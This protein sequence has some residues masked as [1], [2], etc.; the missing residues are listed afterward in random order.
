M[1]KIIIQREPLDIERLI[2]EIGTDSDGA[3][4]TFIGKVRNNSMG[5]D[6]KCMEYEVYNSMAK[7][8]LQKIADNAIARW[9]LNCC[10]I[11]HR[12]GIVNIGEA[13]IFIGVSSPHRDEA[14]QSARYIIDTVKKKVPIW[15]KEFYSDGSEWIN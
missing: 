2:T 8:E 1:N 3:V 12:S 14:F 11:I 7:G 10:I 13:S 5:K 6:V 9:R 15:K 4:V